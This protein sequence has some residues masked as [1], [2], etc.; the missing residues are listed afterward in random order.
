[1]WAAC[2]Q[3]SPARWI[4]WRPPRLPAVLSVPLL[5]DF[6]VSAAATFAFNAAVDDH[7]TVKAN[8]INLGWSGVIFGSCK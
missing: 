7:D 4:D 3:V 6:S 1:M 2:N 8:Q 5:L